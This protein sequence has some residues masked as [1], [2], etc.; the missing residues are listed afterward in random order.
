[1]L[2]HGVLVLLG[3]TAEMKATIPACLSSGFLGESGIAISPDFLPQHSIK[4]L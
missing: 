4:N 1:M 3:V 2:L